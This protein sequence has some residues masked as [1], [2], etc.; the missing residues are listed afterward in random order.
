MDSFLFS[1]PERTATKAN[2]RSP[3]H[4]S[5]SYRNIR[6]LFPTA[7]IEASKSPLVL[8]A[9]PRDIGDTEFEWH[10]GKSTLARTIADTKTDGFL[11]LRGR[12][13]LFEYYAPGSTSQTLHLC[14]S[15]T[16]SI[17]A[18]VALALADR[19]RLDLSALV[20]RYIPE[21]A[22]SA[23]EGATVQQVLDMTIAILYDESYE[24]LDG[25]VQNYRRATGFEPPVPGCAPGL[26]AMHMRHPRGDWPHGQ[27]YHYVSPNTD[28]LGWII[29]RAGGE[30]YARLASDLVWSP[31]GA[32]N[33]AMIVVDGCGAP[34]ACGGFCASLRDL[35]RFGLTLTAANEGVLAPNTVDDI[36]VGGDREAWARRTIDFMPG[37]AYRNQF[38][39]PPGDRQT[40]YAIGIYGQW[41][42]IDRNSGIVIVKQS[43]HD[44]PSMAEVDDRLMACFDAVAAAVR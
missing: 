29:E 21:L 9:S 16:K 39:L 1:P 40:A 24:V 23:Y 32:E 33:E 18:T 22:G 34:V 8:N 7:P 5:W 28:V 38:Y 14:F 41:I 19:G 13:I 30:T 44:R 4:S 12:D 6:Q 10:A 17:T 11:V 37:G 43:C 2:W 3:P 42:Y 15:V 20:T 36:Y 31:M 26:R 35:G 27:R 25:D